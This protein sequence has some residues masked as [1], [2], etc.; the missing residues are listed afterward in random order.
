[1]REVNINIKVLLD[2]KTVKKIEWTS[3]DPPSDGEVLESKAFIL[4]F[5]DKQSLDT[6]RMDLWTDK[7]QIGEMDRLFY[8]TFKGLSESFFHATKNEK[9]ANDMAR[10][11]QYFGEEQGILKRE[12]G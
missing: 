4:S 7:M 8:F 5:F 1:M 3:D 6:F 12:A 2:D 11:A 10:F 9:M